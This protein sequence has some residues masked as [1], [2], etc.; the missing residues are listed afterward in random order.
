MTQTFYKR[1]CQ[2]N[3]KHLDSRPPDHRRHAEIF[4]P[5]PRAGQEGFDESP[6]FARRKGSF[7]KKGGVFSGAYAMRCPTIFWTP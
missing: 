2:K 3:T 1:M 6:C 4:T 7:L 5:D